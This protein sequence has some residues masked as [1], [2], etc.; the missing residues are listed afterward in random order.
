MP[1]KADLV[2]AYRNATG[3]IRNSTVSAVSQVWLSMDSWSDAAAEDMLARVTPIA[4][5]GQRQ[6]ATTTTAYMQQYLGQ[7][8][9]VDF[10]TV[11]G[12]MLRNGTDPLD[13][14][15]RAVRE[16]RI[17]YSRSD[18]VELAV[19]VGMQRLTGA[20]DTD[21][22]LAATHT[23]RAAMVNA[24]VELFRRATR[25]DSCD[26]CKQASQKTY[27]SDELAAIHTHC[28]CI[29]VPAAKLPSRLAQPGPVGDPADSRGLRVIDNDEIGPVLQYDDHG[30]TGRAPSTRRRREDLTPQQTLDMK[31]AQLASYEKVLADGGGTP[32]MRTKV[33]DLRA[34]IDALAS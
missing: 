26:L 11:T 2:T 20:V 19:S 18:L 24:G 31:R 34:E 30:Q 10:D 14:Y 15:A 21:L 17:A 33:T 7:P 4:L 32:W 29:I 28:H 13:V 1:S 27:R 9:D 23:S 12:A 16:A 25:G 3:R 5:A 6:V 8:I 22:Q